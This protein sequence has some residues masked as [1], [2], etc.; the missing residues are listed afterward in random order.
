MKTSAMR[1]SSRPK[2]LLYVIVNKFK[3]LSLL[4]MF[5]DA[6]AQARKWTQTQDIE[7]PTSETT[8]VEPEG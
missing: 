1:A 5:D 2:P 4:Q 8:P 3:L 6:Y 7:E